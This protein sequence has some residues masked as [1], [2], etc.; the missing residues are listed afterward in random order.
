MATDQIDW[1]SLMFDATRDKEHSEHLW[2]Q[3]QFMVH[4]VS[5]ALARLGPETANEIIHTAKKFMKEF[6]QWQ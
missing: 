5:V 3:H 2:Q 4:M 1:I 6:Y